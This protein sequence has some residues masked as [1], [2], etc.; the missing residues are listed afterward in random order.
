[1]QFRGD[2]VRPTAAYPASVYRVC[3]HGMIEATDFRPLLSSVG[4][5]H[6]IPM[7]SFLASTLAKLERAF[8][9]YRSEA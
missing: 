3:T 1:V 2:D 7:A 5:Q 6:C 9:E 8:M 4:A